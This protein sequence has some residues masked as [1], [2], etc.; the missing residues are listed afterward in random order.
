MDRHNADPYETK[1]RY[2]YTGVT[3]VLVPVDL[4]VSG[5]AFEI[6]LRCR[7]SKKSLLEEMSWITFVQEY[8]DG[9]TPNPCIACNRYVK[10]ESL[11]QR[12]L[13]IGADYCKRDIMRA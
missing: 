1:R 10:W 2:E 13:E 3:V 5:T 4:T 7:N 11:L 9:H 8:L 6:P 12:S